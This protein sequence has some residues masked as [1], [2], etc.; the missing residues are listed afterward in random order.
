MRKL[1]TILILLTLF[2]FSYAKILGSAHTRIVGVRETE[3]GTQGMTADLYVEIHEGK[4]RVFVDTM[5]LT[6]I[7]TQA[8]ARLAQEV[9]CE[10]LDANCSGY[11]FFFIIRSQFSMVG[12]PSAGGAMTAAAIAALLNISMNISMNE[13]VIMTGTIN[14]DGSIGPVGGI[15][16]KA[17]AAYNANATYFLIPKGETTVYLTRTQTTQQ[18][19]ITQIVT[20][21]YPVNITEY[22]LKE[23]GLYVI[24]V[25]DVEEALKYLIGYEIVE[26]KISSEEVASK[27]FSTIM[28][29][30]ALELYE[31]ATEILNNTKNLFS[32]ISISLRKRE[33]IQNLIN[34]SSSL[35]NQ[36]NSYYSSGQYYSSASYSVRSI[37]LSIE[38]SQLLNYYSSEIGRNYIKSQADLTSDEIKNL[39]K[40]IFSNITVDNIYD[41]ESIAITAERL[42]E[43]ESMLEEAYKSYYLE[44]YTEAAY[45]LAYAKTRIITAESWSGLMEYFKGNLSMVFDASKLMSLTQRRIE[46]ARNSMTYART[47]VSEQYLTSVQNHLENAD[48]A[49]N[50]GDY[51]Y[52]L[53]EAIKARAEANLIMEIRGTTN[54]SN[55]IDSKKEDAL[56]AIKN[57]EE[58]GLLPILALSYFEYASTFEESEPL[59][60]LILLSYSKDFAKVTKEIVNA[61]SEEQVTPSQPPI[62]KKFT[63]PQPTRD[64]S[65]I[66]VLIAGFF[67]GIVLTLLYYEIVSHKKARKFF[68]V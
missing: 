2:S 10:I 8:S 13:N 16:E 48:D 34:Q 19:P 15:L 63:I 41:I 68:K 3:Q 22:A 23:W 35:L 49:Y 5:P 65:E 61:I 38:A 46:L 12:G 18:G 39:K 57:A 54:Y 28:K 25:R 43:A 11:D 4:G 24:E 62:L 55:K 42:S 67:A 52:A 58:K 44:Q 66:I 21:Q 47:I 40:R 32:T 17:E 59:Q 1:I 36:A 9:A 31:N 53:F 33:E 7:D 60:S 45:Y 56:M 50:R 29:K 30:M 37:I 51:V 27:E 26:K 20:E 14:P 64:K 6:E